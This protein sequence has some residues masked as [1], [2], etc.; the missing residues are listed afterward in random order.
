VRIWRSLQEVIDNGPEQAL[1]MPFHERLLGDRFSLG[2]GGV[3]M[4]CPWSPCR[5]PSGVHG[6]GQRDP[7]DECSGLGDE[8]I[9]TRR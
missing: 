7:V 3:G 1:V 2:A 9:V 4:G 6:P 5:R 8:V